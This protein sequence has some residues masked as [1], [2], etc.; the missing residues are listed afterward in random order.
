[1]HVQT[2]S[3]TICELYQMAMAV[4]LNRLIEYYANIHGVHLYRVFSSI[5][6]K[7]EFTDI[8]WNSHGILR[9]SILPTKHS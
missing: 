6:Y 4:F 8:L 9:K 3:Q 5:K 7:G 1:M 2:G